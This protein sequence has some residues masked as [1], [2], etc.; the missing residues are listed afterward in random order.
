MSV[1]RGKNQYK[2]SIG[3][4]QID[5]P[6]VFFNENVL[7]AFGES[8]SVRLTEVSVLWDVRLKRFDCIHLQ[9]FTITAL[10]TYMT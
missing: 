5:R 6:I 8:R 7:L 10:S 4:L 3:E 1:L 2:S 9:Y